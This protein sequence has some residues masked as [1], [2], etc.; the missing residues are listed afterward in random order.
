MDI[1]KWNEIPGSHAVEG[2]PYTN[3]HDLNLDWIIKIVKDFLDQ[4]SHIQETLQTGLDDLDAKATEI[5]GLLQDWYDTHSNDIAQQLA[6]AVVELDS[7]ISQRYNQL[8]D[9]ID[10]KA[11]ETLANI[12]D[13]Y[14]ALANEVHQ[15]AESIKTDR[16]LLTEEMFVNKTWEQGTLLGGSGEGSD[17]LIRIRTGYMY[18]SP[19]SYLYIYPADRQI[20]VYFYDDNK[21]YLSD[22]GEWLTDPFIYKPT[23][24]QYIRVVVSKLDATQNITPT[25]ANCEIYIQSTLGQTISNDSTAVELLNTNS[26]NSIKWV[27]RGLRATGLWT[28]IRTDRVTMQFPVF[29]PE[30]SNLT[31]VPDSSEEFY[32]YL[33]DTNMEMYKKSSGW[34]AD[35]QTITI[36]KNSYFN[37][38]LRKTSGDIPVNSKRT[39]FYIT[40]AIIN[41]INNIPFNDNFTFVQGGLS[42]DG[43]TPTDSPERIR[44]EN[45]TPVTETSIIRITA[46]GQA[47][48]WYLLDENDNIIESAEAW[49]AS[50]SDIVIPMNSFFN[51]TIRKQ[52]YSTILPSER[53]TTFQMMPYNMG[54]YNYSGEQIT[55]G[56]HSFHAEDM[57]TLSYLPSWFQAGF[58]HNSNMF[59]SDNNS[60]FVYDKTTGIQQ[61]SFSLDASN[62]NHSNTINR[63]NKHLNGNPIPLI[64][65]SEFY[66]EGRIFVNDIRTS[67]S[68]FTAT[69][70]QTINTNQL[71]GDIVGRGYTDFAI[72]NEAQKLYVIKYALPETIQ[73]VPGNYTII[74]EYNLPDISNQNVTLHDNDI[75][76]VYTIN[77]LIFARQQCFIHNGKVYMIAGTGNNSHLYVIDLNQEKIV[78]DIYLVNAI[79]AHEPEACMIDEGK[80]II[81]CAGTPV[82]K[83]LIF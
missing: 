70:V 69:K 60:V 52:D 50:D 15:V 38:V 12:P 19:N 47:Y 28:D 13:D 57:I 33:F 3:L 68:T 51:V 36:T 76:N 58:L 23:S 75:L 20:W 27:Q 34:T 46:N 74:T 55:I 22:S 4:Y 5:E 49:N 54:L 56:K 21:T 16:E 37:I 64:Y 18:I 59:I 30:L 83:Q 10:Q 78:T 44:I 39:I 77:H 31:I 41:I 81:V 79:N 80:M 7:V 67:G 6:N 66:G 48:Y 62:D 43:H 45:K 65:I 42:T 26:V 71:N 11:E 17:S 24:A 1:K 82:V 63:S 32:F 53:T 2:W 40:P 8:I 14:T 25:E 35:T 29:I 73:A 72:N 9:N 61:T